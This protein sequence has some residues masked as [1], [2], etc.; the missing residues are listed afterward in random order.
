MANKLFAITSPRRYMKKC[1]VLMQKNQ[2]TARSP[3]R[4]SAGRGSETLLPEELWDKRSY[5]PL[6]VRTKPEESSFRFCLL[7][8]QVL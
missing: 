4:Q 6:R 8:K 5:T 3:S 7:K 1:L 2:Q